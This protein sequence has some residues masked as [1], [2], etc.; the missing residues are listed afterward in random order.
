MR[1]AEFRRRLVLAGSAGAAG[2][3]ALTV[4]NAIGVRRPDLTE[5][6]AGE[7]LSVL[8]PMRDEAEAARPCLTA[9]LRAVDRWPGPVRILVLDDDST[10]GTGAILDSMS[11]QD[12]RI[13]VIRGRP[14]P[15]GWLGK[16]WA[17]AQLAESAAEDG[18]LV[19]L[20]ADVI[21][22]PEA[23][24]S[25]AALLRRTGLDLISPYPRQ[26]ADTAAER[27]VQP[28]LQWSW[29]STLPLRLAE[30]SP[31]ESLS[32]ANGQ[33]IVVDA[34]TYRR[35]GGHG[36]VRDIVLE[37]IALLRAVKATGGRGVVVEGSGVASCRMYDGWAQVRAGYRKS[38]WSAFGSP[39]GTLAVTALLVLLYVVPAVAA[40]LGSRTGALGYLAGVA[41]RV[42]VAHTTAGRAWP[43]ALAHPLSIL[44]FASL[45]ADSTLAHRRGSLT[46]KG[47][48]IVEVS[49]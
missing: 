19:F 40:L 7:P 3:L 31:R 26:I 22:E 37:D 17:C 32:A 43:D 28:L 35:A 49:R 11:E 45:A 47:R 27:V 23:F 10:D 13:E 29:M 42:I 38:L 2:C 14:L 20:D 48:T 46:W 12:D 15:D 25:S 41:S 21:V 1:A 8:V 18:V 24:T 6:P 34:Q 33:L 39:A 9:V 44:V 30:H 16:T 36:A 4:A 5:V